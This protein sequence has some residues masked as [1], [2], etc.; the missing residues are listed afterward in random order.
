MTR[1]ISL[2][3]HKLL[4]T[5]LFIAA[6]NIKSNAQVVPDFN[7]DRI[8]PFDSILHIEDTTEYKIKKW[9][10]LKLDH[11]FFIED[12][13]TFNSYQVQLLK[14]NYR[15]YCDYS[16]SLKFYPSP[17]YYLNF[18]SVIID[19]TLLKNPD[20]HLKTLSQ[21]NTYTE[22]LV[23]EF[24][25]KKINEDFFISHPHLVKYI[26]KTVPEPHRLITDRKHLK[27]RSAQEGIVDLLITEINKPEKLDKR[28][29]E[30]GPWTIGGI[31]SVQLSQAYLSNWTKGGE[32]SIALRSDLQI[33]ANYTEKKVEWENYIRHKIGIIS[34]ESYATQ[35][36]TDQIEANSK[37]GIK[38]SKRWYYSALFDFKTQFFNGYNNKARENVISSFMS[39]AYLTLAVGMDYKKDK[40]FTLLLSP[41]TS[42][43]TYIMDTA[44]VDPANYKIPDGKKVAFNNGASLVNNIDWKISTELNL[45]S[46]LDAFV[47]YLNKH[48]STQIDWELIFDMRINRFL[49]TRINTQLRY[50]D[51]ES[52]KLQFKE[53]FAINFN[54][55]F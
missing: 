17:E 20:G 43:L 49:S 37:Y 1:F 21:Y 48:N 51:N 22:Y 11:K 16:F 10:Q 55:K 3:A 14:T 40:T 34:S 26:L 6:F 12:S 42:K 44:R 35:I 25:P 41:W 15:E 13:A 7:P 52:N 32:N 28:I 2:S 5:L 24:D 47:G 38:A 9:G 33:N 8:I 30:K 50:F 18:K 45:K 23:D 46:K 53:Y 4:I 31:E 54:Y 36:N 19:T 39:P 29:K 27:R